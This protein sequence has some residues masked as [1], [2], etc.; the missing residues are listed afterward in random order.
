[1][2]AYVD[3][4]AEYR[5]LASVVDRPNTSLS[6]TPALFTGDRSRIFTAMQEAYL[7]YGDLSTEGVEQ[8]YG[9]MLPPE[10]EA[11]R[12]AKAGAI[13]ERLTQLASKRQIGDLITHLSIAMA[14]SHLGR[15]EIARL[16]VLPPL[17]STDDSSITPGITT[18]VSDIGRKINKQY[19]FVSTGLSFLDTMLGGEWPR[20]ALTVVLAAGGGGKTALTVQSIL[21]MARQGLPVLF[22]S[23]E[24]PRDR[25]IGR[26]VA[27]I[28][29]VNGSRIR[30]GDVTEDE[31]LLINS[32]LEEIQS[33]EKYIFI[34]DRPGLNIT[35]IINQIRLHKDTYDIQ[36]FFVDYLQIIDRPESENTSDALGYLAQQLRNIAV[37]LDI[38]AIVLSQQNRGFQGLASILGSGRVG[39][40]A[41]AAFEIV[42]DTAS[43]NDDSRMTT[44]TFHKNRDGAVGTISCIYKPSVLT[45]V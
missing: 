7:T 12:G 28:T 20:Q 38:S 41:D 14:N 22:I 10:I 31:Q 2:S 5:L 34:I 36:A 32:A 39:H 40:I 45:F 1:M 27:S 33:L 35:E 26:M 8:F 3:E 4:I 16:L 15:D 43:T 21:S 17:V 25:L 30:N 6:Y 42:F 9:R 23:L 19:R 37:M 29:G 44:I 24:M 11:A 18:F 13:I